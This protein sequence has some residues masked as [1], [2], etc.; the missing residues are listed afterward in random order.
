M[1]Q[2]HSGCNFIY[3]LTARPTGPRKG[4]L[5]IDIANAKAPHSLG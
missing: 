5:K 4:F 1:T 3:V 2:C